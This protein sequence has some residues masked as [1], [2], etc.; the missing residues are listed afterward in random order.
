MAA[1]DLYD[2]GSCARGHRCLRLSGYHAIFRCEQIERRL[3]FPCR[4]SDLALDGFKAPR[5]LGGSHELR[6][7]GIY[8]GRECG[9]K[10]LRIDFDEAIVRRKEWGFF[11]TGDLLRSKV[12]CGFPDVGNESCQINESQ[13]L[14]FAPGFGDHGATIGMSDEH[15]WMFRLG[16]HA[17]GALNILVEGYGR[18]LNNENLI[19]CSSRCRRS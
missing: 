11:R 3:G 17:F 16:D 5:P 4:G 6:F 7:G 2:R 13:D 10:L 18:V 14:F 19:V 12:E 15:N 8:V 9:R 1:A